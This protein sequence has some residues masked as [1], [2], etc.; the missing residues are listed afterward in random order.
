M[1]E[2]IYARQRRLYIRDSEFSA[3]DINTLDE[4]RGKDL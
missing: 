4:A 2:I 3:V 1:D